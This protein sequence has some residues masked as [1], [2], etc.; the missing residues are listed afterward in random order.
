MLVI[1]MVVVLLVRM[2]LLVVTVVEV[3][4]TLVSTVVETAVLMWVMW[5]CRYWCWLPWLCRCCDGAED[6][7]YVGSVIMELM[8]TLSVVALVIM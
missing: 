1:W 5:C 3:M 4:V 2:L 7:G 8:V 6:G